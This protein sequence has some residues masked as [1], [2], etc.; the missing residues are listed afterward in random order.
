MG[1]LLVIS[2][3]NIQILGK[4]YFIVI[5]FLKPYFVLKINLFPLLSEGVVDQQGLSSGAST[6]MLCVISRSYHPCDGVIH[7]GTAAPQ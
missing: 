2:K 7:C 3:D 6:Y 1:G 4:K 5:Y